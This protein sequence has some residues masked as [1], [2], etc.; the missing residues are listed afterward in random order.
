MFIFSDDRLGYVDTVEDL[1]YCMDDF[2]DLILTEFCLFNG[3][4]QEH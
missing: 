4:F 2:G 1:M 3:Y